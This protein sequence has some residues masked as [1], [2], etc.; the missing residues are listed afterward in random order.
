MANSAAQIEERRKQF[1]EQQQKLK[2]RMN[3]VK[4]KIAEE[5]NISF[6]GSIPIDQKIS[7]DSDKGVFFIIEH[8]DS[9][10]SRAFMEIVTNIKGFLRSK[11]KPTR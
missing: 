10:S 11:E 2:T 6:L 1:L 8:S 3:K 5:L 9:P 4:H 7:E